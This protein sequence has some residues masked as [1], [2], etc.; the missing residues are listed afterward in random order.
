VI[1]IT[2]YP[3]RRFYI[4]G[5]GGRYLTLTQI[6]KMPEGTYQ[7]TD[8]RTRMDLTRKTALTAKYKEEM[9]HV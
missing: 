7:V 1:K 4:S 6:A 5:S 3:N 2:K 9:K 8:H